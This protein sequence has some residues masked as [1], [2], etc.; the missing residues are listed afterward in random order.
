MPKRIKTGYPGVYYREAARIGKP[1]VE[2]VFYVTFKRAGK[3]IEEKVGRQYADRMTEAKANRIRSDLIE[4]RRRLRKEKRAAEAV[5]KSAG[6]KPWTVDR[7]FAAYKEAKPDLKGWS[8]GTYDSL[9]EK[10]IKP[11]FGKMEPKDIISLDVKRVQNRLAKTHS[12]QMVKHVLKMLRVLCNFGARN[13]LC[14]GL[15]FT[16]TMPVVNNTKTEDLTPAELQRLLDAIDKDPH[17]QAGPMMLMALYTGMRAGEMFRLRWSHVDFERGFIHI[18]DPKGGQD[19]TIPLND[20]A[21]ELL[22][23]HRRRKGSPFVFP[24][25]AGRQRT[26]IDKAANAIKTAAKLPANFR[27]LHGLRH[28]YASMLASSGEVDMYV[29]QRLLTHKSPQMTQRYAHLRDE[30]LRK[31][32]GL[33]GDMVGKMRKIKDEEKEKSA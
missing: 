25:R 10:H 31:A 29:L 11:A 13:N 30:A 24:G 22:K 16:I 27:P 8:H 23:G 19:Q 20:A 14:E 33:A 4:G 17:P 7:L 32:S 18:R 28:V 21:R 26:R 15:R 12:P 6:V 3:V 9:Y 5:E 2:R 1:G